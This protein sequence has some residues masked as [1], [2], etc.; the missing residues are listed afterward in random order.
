L[1]VII[2][3]EHKERER[4][5]GRERREDRKRK[6]KKRTREHNSN[7]FHFFFLLADH[8]TVGAHSDSYYEY[9]LKQWLQ[10]NRT[11][12]ILKGLYSNAIDSMRSHLIRR[13]RTGKYIMGM[14][15]VREREKERGE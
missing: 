15:R 1:S 14:K 12:D 9:L 8:K 4:E 6:R 10:T 13:S 7:T 11:D 3:R 5:R 2:G